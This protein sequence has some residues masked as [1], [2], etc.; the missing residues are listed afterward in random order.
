MKKTNSKMA[1][2]V[3]L[4]GAV[5]S[6][7]IVMGKA[8]LYKRS[9][10]SVSQ[11]LVDDEEVQHQLEE[12]ER[13]CSKA[14]QELAQLLGHQQEKSAE[15]LVRTQI[16]MIKDPELHRQIKRQ[17]ADQNQPA[18][19]AVESVFE[20]YLS[21]MDRNKSQDRSVDITDVRDRLIQFLHNY[22]GNEIVEGSIV[23]TRELSPREVIECA[24]H[25]VKGIVRV[26]GG[27]NSH[28]A[29]MARSIGLPTVLGTIDGTAEIGADDQ[30]ILDAE[31][32]QVII[33]P[34]ADTEQ[35]YQELIARQSSAR[36]NAEQICQKVNETSDGT[37]FCLRANMEFIEE[38][39]IVQ[40]YRAEGIGLLRTESIYLRD[41]NFKEV[42]KHQSCYHSVLQKTAPHPVVIRLFDAGGDKLLDRDDREPN[43]FLGWRGIRML[44]D[45]KKLLTYQLKAI[46]RA[47]SKHKGRVRILIPMVS[48]VA[49]VTEVRSLLDAVQEELRDKGL[50]PDDQ[51]QLGIM[52]EVPNVALQADLF[53]EHVDFL[54][55]GTNDLTQYLLAVDRGN[56]RIAHLYDQRHPIV[57]RL[58][59]EVV[60]A[61]RQTNTL[62]SICGE[63]ASNPVAACGLMG[64]GISELS[65]NSSMLPAVKEALC[66][67]KM[68]EMQNFAQQILQCQTMDDINQ[69]FSNW[70]NT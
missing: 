69:L 57:W 17:I 67:H 63:L 21:M 6:P 14:E 16:E 45:E 46:C 26:K 28:A 62:L 8:N 47:A 24:D 66:N 36:S 18:D 35:K 32:G 59:N 2:D 3:V 23:V 29:I 19:A 1:R 50:I 27:I 55:I 60:E 44:L 5:G 33:N 65:M 43:P 37:P 31:S 13:A 7:G 25:N 48:T 10:P 12:F 42:Q 15:E 56:E 61:A 64:L 52:V 22:D 41:Q 49:E 58:I 30:I 11:S 34:N 40:K 4:S 20:T 38:L 53:A 68:S 54:S 70:K 39:D 9:R 51:I